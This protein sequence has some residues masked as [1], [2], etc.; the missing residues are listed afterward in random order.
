MKTCFSSVP[1]WIFFLLALFTGIM[2]CLGFAI[3]IKL[4]GVHFAAVYAYLSSG[5]RDNTA[6]AVA[7]FGFALSSTLTIFGRASYI[8]YMETLKASK[9]GL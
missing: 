7:I 8:L 5:M 4:H 2:G 6:L 1:S 9:K 3:V